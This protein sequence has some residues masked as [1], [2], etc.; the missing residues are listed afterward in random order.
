MNRQRIGLQ[1]DLPAPIGKQTAVERQAN[2]AKV[3]FG[4]LEGIFRKKAVRA[5]WRTGRKN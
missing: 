1:T 3:I 5:T 2:V 4:P